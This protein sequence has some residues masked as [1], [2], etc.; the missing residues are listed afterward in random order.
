M[1]INFKKNIQFT[2]TAKTNGRVR[3]FNFRKIQGTDE[4]LFHV[5]VSDERG[6]RIMFRMHKANGQWKIV[7][8]EMPKWVWDAENSL[9][10]L[11]EE[12]LQ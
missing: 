10:E 6:N 7:N 1:E 11:I 12:E 2:R 3:E 4:E 5:D 9:H 8:Q